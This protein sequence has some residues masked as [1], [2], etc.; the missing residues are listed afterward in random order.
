MKERDPQQW[1][2]VSGKVSILETTLL[3]EAFF[4]ELLP[5]EKREDILYRIRDSSL[6][7]YFHTTDDLLNYEDI[8]ND[9]YQSQVREIRRFS[10]SPAVCDFFLLPYEFMNLKNF[11]KEELYGLPPAGRFPGTI[12]ENVWRELWRGGKR[13]SLPD[14]YEEALS[15]LKESRTQGKADE[16]GDPGLVDSI[17]DGHQLHYLPALMAGL[18][19]ELICGYVRDYRRLKGILM[20]Q[21]VPTG[22]EAAALWF[23]KEDELFKIPVQGA[24]R[25]WREML[26]EIVPEKIVEKIITGSRRDL[27]SRYEKYTG[28]YLMEKL[29]PARYAA[30]GPGKVFRYLSALTAEL[31]NLRLLIGGAL[32]KL[33]PGVTGNMLRRT[34]F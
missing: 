5:L 14:V 3:R 18:E 16:T 19:S 11:L 25:H 33:S 17:L 4:Q 32:N 21:R 29:E 2:F 20:L 10:P 9:R 22:S 15:A 31:F 34:C 1:C 23:L 30:F 28:D 6:R 27:L 7:D 13:P 8:A 26:L 12:S 24:P